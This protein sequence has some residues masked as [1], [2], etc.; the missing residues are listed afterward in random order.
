MADDDDEPGINVAQEELVAAIAKA[1]CAR[2]VKG[3]NGQPA[4]TTL[5]PWGG[6]PAGG[7]GE[8]T[9]SAAYREDGSPLQPQPYRYDGNKPVYALTYHDAREEA[10]SQWEGERVSE[11]RIAAYVDKLPE[12]MY[13]LGGKEFSREDV[14]LEIDSLDQLWVHRGVHYEPE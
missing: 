1:F 9:A 6:W 14:P 8:Y 7:G 13:T 5:Y 2:E 4:T 12:G 10:M 11:A 3:A